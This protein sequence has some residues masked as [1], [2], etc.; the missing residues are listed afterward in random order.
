MWNVSLELI[1]IVLHS[2]CKQS[3]CKIAQTSISVSEPSLL[4]RFM[5]HIEHDFSGMTEMDE[6]WDTFTFKYMPQHTD[7]SLDAGLG[8]SCFISW[9]YLLISVGKT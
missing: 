9:H 1:F 8:L 7:L 5:S 3:F 4:E 2:F 6:M